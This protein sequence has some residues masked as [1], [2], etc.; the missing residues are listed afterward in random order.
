MLADIVKLVL[1]APVP[2]AEPVCKMQRGGSGSSPSAPTSAAAALTATDGVTVCGLHNLGNTCFLNAVLQCFLHTPWLDKLHVIDQSGGV[3]CTGRCRRQGSDKFCA[4]CELEFLR[5][6]M[7][8]VVRS[9]AGGGGGGGGVCAVSPHDFVLNIRH[10]LGSEP[11]RQEDAHEAYTAVRSKLEVA[12]A[13]SPEHARKGDTVISTLLGG[14]LQSVV[15]VTGCCNGRASVTIDP[16]LDL[17]LEIGDRVRPEMA[18]FSHSGDDAMPRII[19]RH[20]C[21]SPDPA[22]LPYTMFEQ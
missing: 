19:R 13:A 17:N 16:F 7:L 2:R 5:A 9:G 3:Q 14:H 8:A 15:N 21:R 12:L 20:G 11:G 4:Y 6:S 1:R 18:H 22:E 10:A